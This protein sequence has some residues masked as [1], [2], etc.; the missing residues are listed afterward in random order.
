M[1]GTPQYQ[2]LMRQPHMG[3]MGQ[4]PM[5]KSKN[6]NQI[7][8]IVVVGLL[9]LAF[10][11]WTTSTPEK[12]CKFIN[13]IRGDEGST[14]RN[15]IDKIDHGCDNLSNNLNNVTKCTAEDIECTNGEVDGMKPTRLPPGAPPEAALYGCS[16]NCDYVGFYGEKCEIPKA[17]CKDFSCPAKWTN[18]SE[19]I[20]PEDP[21]FQHYCLAP[22]EG[23]EAETGCDKFTCC[24]KNSD[25]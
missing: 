7:I 1:Y 24:T 4:M 9:G 11:W 23:A 5:R 16:C 3:Y 2:M 12:R 20:D 8:L 14:I 13:S 22:K 15:L 17:N 19:I 25:L 6:D 21:D 18:N 10:Y